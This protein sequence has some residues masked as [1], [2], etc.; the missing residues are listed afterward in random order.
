MCKNKQQQKT[1]IKSDELYTV[2]VDKI[3]SNLLWQSFLQ[4][5]RCSR[6]FHSRIFCAQLCF[7]FLLHISR[8]LINK[9]I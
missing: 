2:D 8:D 5:S 6:A 9:Y 7:L 1:T 3:C 4:Q